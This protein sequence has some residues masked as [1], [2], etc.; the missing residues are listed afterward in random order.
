MKYNRQNRT[1]NPLE[2]ITP[3]KDTARA[4]AQLASPVVPVVPPT[5][6]AARSGG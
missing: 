4:R 1:E 2:V 3:V 5:A 6:R